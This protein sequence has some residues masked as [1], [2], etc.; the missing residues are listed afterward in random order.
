MPAPPPAD[1]GRHGPRAPFLGVR[2]VG[3]WSGHISY[4]IICIITNMIIITITNLIDIMC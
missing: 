1:H 4:I 2:P 3:H